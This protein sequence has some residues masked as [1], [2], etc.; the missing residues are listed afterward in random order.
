MAER[1][2]FVAMH[3]RFCIYTVRQMPIVK[4]SFK[5][6]MKILPRNMRGV[7]VYVCVCV[8]ESERDRERE[9]QRATERVRGRDS[10]KGKENT[11]AL[12]RRPALVLIRFS[13]TA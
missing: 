12:W 11:L 7:C 1:D 4:G 3:C 6:L 13:K 2:G 9:R 8:R 5:V 10:E